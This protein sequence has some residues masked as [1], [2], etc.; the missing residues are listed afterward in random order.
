VL[1]NTPEAAFY[2]GNQMEKRKDCLAAG[3]REMFL[4][5]LSPFAMILYYT[6]SISWL[7]LSSLNNINNSLNACCQAGTTRNIFQYDIG[8]TFW[9]I[10]FPRQIPPLECT[11]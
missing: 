8:S 1:H 5:T 2:Q 10:A 9:V 11:Y 3:L 4:T 7:Y 6:R